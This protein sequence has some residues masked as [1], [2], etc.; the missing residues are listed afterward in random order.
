MRRIILFFNKPVEVFSENVFFFFFL[1]LYKRGAS[2]RRCPSNCPAENLS[3]WIVVL[4][5]PISCYVDFL[6]RRNIQ[7]VTALNC[8]WSVQSVQTEGHLVACLLCS[9]WIESELNYQV[10]LPTSPFGLRVCRVAWLLLRPRTSRATA[11]VGKTHQSCLF[12]SQH[13]RVCGSRSREWHRQIVSPS[14]QACQEC[15]ACNW[16]RGAICSRRRTAY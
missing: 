2:W 12:F 5:S 11:E 8:G 15:A 4:N 6:R 1:S 3:S 16:S 9:L 10:L 7:E 14:L 13:T